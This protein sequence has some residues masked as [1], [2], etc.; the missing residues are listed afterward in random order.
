MHIAK[1]LAEAQKGETNVSKFD[2]KLRYTV[3][4]V[5]VIIVSSL[6]VPQPRVAA[7]QNKV[8]PSFGSLSLSLPSAANLTLVAVNGTQYFLNS[9]QIAA[10]PSTTG[11]GGFKPTGGTPPFSTNNFTGVSLNTLANQVGGLS[12]SEVLAI[13]SSDG[14]TKNFTYAQVVNGNF[15]GSTYNRTTGNPTSPTKPIVATI[16]YYN[17]SQLIPPGPSGRGPL[18]VAIVG[19][20]SLV[21]PGK[22]WSKWVVKLEI[23]PVSPLLA[24]ASSGIAGYKLL[25]NETMTNPFSTAAVINYNWN[26]T[27]QKWNGTQWVTS[28]LNGSST[29][30]TGYSI[31]ANATV[32]LPYSVCLLPMSGPNAVS[33]GD[34]LKVSYVFHWTYSG[35]GYSVSYSVKLNVHPGDTSGATV[36]PPYFGADGKVSTGDLTLLARNWGKSVTWTGTIDP[37]DELHRADTG[38]YGKVSTGDLTIL[39]RYWGARGVWNNTPPPG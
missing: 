29:P 20:D 4:V 21:T 23:L 27:M 26:F 7:T 22:L 35:T 28:S 39:A 8:S 1:T 15:S 18:M 11:P 16:A 25:F 38:M 13:V 24:A 14:Y 5:F 34:W 2:I 19:N 10:L 33:N 36:A 9:T 12:S 30:V 3:L 6:I 37:T 31:P 32:E 17:N